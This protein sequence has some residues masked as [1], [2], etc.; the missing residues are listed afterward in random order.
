[1]HELQLA[2]MCFGVTP[3]G[4]LVRTAGP[5][6][7][8]IPRFLV[9]EVGGQ[10]LAY[11]R[12]DLPPALRDCLNALPADRALRDHHAAETILAQHG[13]CADRW[14][15]TSYVFGDLTVRAD[16]RLALMTADEVV[17]DLGDVLAALAGEPADALG[18]RHIGRVR[19]TLEVVDRHER[20]NSAGMVAFSA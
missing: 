1:L 10:L 9:V 18:D 14:A 20:L 17:H 7:E 5:E 16:G 6:P 19:L 13:P 11:A 2:L 3:G 4:T 15:G 8:E 12:D